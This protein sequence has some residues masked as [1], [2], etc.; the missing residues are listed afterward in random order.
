MRQ[1]GAIWRACQDRACPN[2]SVVAALGCWRLVVNNG[3]RRGSP[4]CHADR[5]PNILLMMADDW[6][7]GE[8]SSRGHPFLATPH[9]SS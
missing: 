4:R 3:H 2:S 1:F 8:L 6:G 5:P 7:F 9:A